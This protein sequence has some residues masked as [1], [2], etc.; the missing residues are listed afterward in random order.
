MVKEKNGNPYEEGALSVA[1]GTNRLSTL[2]NIPFA[3]EECADRI[4]GNL[5]KL[6]DHFLKKNL[7]DFTKSYELLTTALQDNERQAKKFNKFH[8][9]A[10]SQ[11]NIFLHKSKKELSE[12]F[13]TTSEKVPNEFLAFNFPLLLVIK[14]KNSI[15]YSADIEKE[16]NDLEEVGR[17]IKTT[18]DQLKTPINQKK[19]DALRGQQEKLK[20]ITRQLIAS[21]EKQNYIDAAAKKFISQQIPLLH[22]NFKSE[23][24][25]RIA[26]VI[27]EQNKD[28]KTSRSDTNSQS[29]EPDKKRQRKA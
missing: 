14:N 18:V 11:L 7:E 29:D 9:I 4:Y 15:Y 28:I 27:E 3:S 26:A 8:I 24:D 6:T 19:L 21:I 22:N 13:V 25:K 2:F 17:N 16:I 10:Q 5:T 23:A 1:I 12:N 20:A